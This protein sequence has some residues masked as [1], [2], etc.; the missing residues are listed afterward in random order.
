MGL[1]TRI[2]D[3][4]KNPSE[5]R[6]SLVSNHFNK[7]PSLWHFTS[8]QIDHFNRSTSTR[9]FDANPSLR[10]VTDSTRDEI[11]LEWRIYVKVS[12]WRVCGSEGERICVLLTDL[13]RSDRFWG[14]Q[15][16]CTLCG[17]EGY[18]QKISKIFRYLPHF[19]KNPSN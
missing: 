18:S 1:G 3:N 9:H 15:K 8:T 6:V 4:Q 11:V 7:N 12:K 10:H 5:K 14:A 17:S 16:E 19:V 13:C 2:W